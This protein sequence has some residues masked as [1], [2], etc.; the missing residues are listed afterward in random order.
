[1]GLLEIGEDII[2]LV[3]EGGVEDAG[4][5]GNID[6]GMFPF[7]C[8]II[9][10]VYPGAFHRPHIRDEIVDRCGIITITEQGILQP[11]V[12][13]GVFIDIGEG[14]G[15]E[16]EGELVE[17]PVGE[18]YGKWFFFVGLVIDG[19]DAVEGGLVFSIVVGDVE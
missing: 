16:L 4:P 9:Q 12:T 18:L 15:D 6:E 13:H 5:E 8:I 19:F 17:G 2:L 3:D 7:F 11:G 10:I 14:I 1:L